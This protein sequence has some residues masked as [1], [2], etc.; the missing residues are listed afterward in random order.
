MGFRKTVKA[1]SAGEDV[2]VSIKELVYKYSASIWA[3]IVV[4]AYIIG[5][6]YV[7]DA[8]ENGGGNNASPPNNSA[9]WTLIDCWYFLCFTFCTIGY[10]DLYPTSD[11]SRL[12]A[13][14]MVTSVDLCPVLSLC[15]FLES[16]NNTRRM[17]IK[18]CSKRDRYAQQILVG[19]STIFPTFATYVIPWYSP[20]TKFLRNKFDERIKPPK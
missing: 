9:D 17:H 20:L 3:L 8:L 19:V 10:G 11:G 7:F 1:I 18:Y 16:R 13:I 2:F 5:G 15:L 12:F 4:S 6:I 14:F